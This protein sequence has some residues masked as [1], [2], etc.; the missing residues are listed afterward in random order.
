MIEQYGRKLSRHYFYGERIQNH[1]DSFPNDPIGDFENEIPRS[2]PHEETSLDSGLPSH[3][4]LGEVPC[5]PTLHTV[6]STSQLDHST[7]QRN[8][9]TSGF[10]NAF[11]E[12]NLFL[13]GRRACHEIES[14]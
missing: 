14:L 5:P 4:S 9:S 8:T 7:K 10:G 1:N 12:V 6:F 3:L 13:T 2:F 11:L